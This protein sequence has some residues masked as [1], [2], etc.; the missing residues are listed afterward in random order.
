[1][2]VAIYTAVAG[3]YDALLPQPAQ[4][5]DVDWIAFTDEPLDLPEPWQRRPLAPS[6]L[7]PRMAAKAPKCTP[8]DFLGDEYDAAVWI[9]G[10]MGVTSPAFAR[11]AL[12]CRHDG[13]AT[14]RHPQRRC[15]YA[16]A[17]ASLRLCPLKYGGH[18]IMEQVE[19][20]RAEG[21]PV[22][23]GLYACGTLAWDLRNPDAR[24]LGTAWLAECVRWTYQDQ[25]SLPVVARR[26]GVRPGRFPH[27]QVTRRS[28]SNP[29]LTIHPHR[30][31]D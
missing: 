10:N 19:H 2:R 13:L 22:N 31:D 30:R 3:G 23:G 6:S 12:A 1:M 21:H 8:W 16:E 7:G 18:P 20:Y 17:A 14:W 9:D 11:E 15:I 24:A 28:L 5:I 27:S 26:L 25:L 29:W 4:D